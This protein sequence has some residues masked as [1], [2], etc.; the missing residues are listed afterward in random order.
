[1][2]IR[3]KGIV[4]STERRRATE[5]WTDDSGRKVAAQPKRYMAHIAIGDM[6][7]GNTSFFDGDIRVASAQITLSEYKRLRTQKVV[8]CIAEQKGKRYI[9][10]A[11]NGIEVVMIED[12]DD[13]LDEDEDENE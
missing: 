5:E 9:L 12:D 4:L 3:I 7:D 2:K 11:V 6:P 10:H 13:K 1:M 8:D